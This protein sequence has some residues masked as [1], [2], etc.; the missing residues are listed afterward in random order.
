MKKIG[1]WTLHWRGL[2]HQNWWSLIPQSELPVWAEVSLGI[3]VICSCP[4]SHRDELPM[5]FLCQPV[6][7]VKEWVGD[8]KGSVEGGPSSLHREPG[9]RESRSASKISVGDPTCLL[10]FST[11]IFARPSS[12]IFKAETHTCRIRQI[13]SFLIW[14]E[15]NGGAIGRASPAKSLEKLK[16]TT[17]FFYLFIYFNW[18][19]ITLQYCGGFCHTFTWISQG[20]TCVPHPEPPFHLPPHPIPVHLPWAPCLMHLTCTD[21]LL[22]EMRD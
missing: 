8:Q 14:K 7:A 22:R 9:K 15:G 2:F 21:F 12:S 20:C 5:K 4:L 18:R 1:A 13:L 6:L 11:C 3:C 10:G 19:L 17:D 16:G